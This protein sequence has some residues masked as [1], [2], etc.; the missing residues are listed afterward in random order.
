MQAGSAA[1]ALYRSAIRRRVIRAGEQ[2]KPQANIRR[3]FTATQRVA[4]F[5]KRGKLGGQRFFS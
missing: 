2:I 3:G 1:N 4:F 5:Q